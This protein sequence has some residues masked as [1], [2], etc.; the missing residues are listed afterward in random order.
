MHFVYGTAPGS[1]DKRSARG[2]HTFDL[3]LTVPK[4]MVR[5]VL[6]GSVVAES[7]DGSVLRS[8]KLRNEPRGSAQL[9]I[10]AVRL[11]L[12][13]EFEDAT[14]ETVGAYEVLRMVGIEDGYRYLVALRVQ[15]RR[16]HL[17]EAYFPSA[18]HEARQS[19]AVRAVLAAG[20]G[21]P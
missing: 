5:L 18:D 19:D 16:L 11:R 21:A 14:V 12:A 1:A 2:A 8:G 13:P 17:V 6:R 9:W 3:K 7:P 10:E 15:G 20:G 4:G